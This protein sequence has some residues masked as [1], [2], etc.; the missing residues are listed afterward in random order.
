MSILFLVGRILFGGFFV[1][2]SY[3]HFFN[4]KDLAAYAVSKGTPMA[5]LSVYVAGFLIL[6]GG[7]GIILGVYVYWSIAAISLFLI[8]VTGF[9]HR[10]WKEQDPMSKASNQVNFYKN[11]ALLGAALMFLAIS[12]P[13][14][15]SLF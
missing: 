4:N 12:T 6:F 10:Y 1:K 3:G 15:I 11:L 7:L 14:P 2:S 5:G 13:W 9:M 8:V